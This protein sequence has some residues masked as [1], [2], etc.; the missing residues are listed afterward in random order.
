MC[1]CLVLLL[2]LTLPVV[3]QVR[4]E[5]APPKHVSMEEENARAQTRWMYK[6]LSLEAE[7]YEQVNEINLTYAY[8]FDSIEKLKSKAAKTSA[9][10]RIKQTKEA[11][12]KAVLTPDQY[13]QYVAHKEKQ[14]SQKKSPFSGSYLGQ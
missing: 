6:N 5:S 12:I 3:A 7:Q 11:R 10:N 2:C 9:K 4:N 13:L 8:K 1:S 14:A